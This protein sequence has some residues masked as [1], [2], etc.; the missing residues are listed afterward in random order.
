MNLDQWLENVVAN[1]PGAIYRCELRSD[2][3]M[4][5]MSREIEHITG[6]PPS[7]FVGNA[8]RTY[9]SVIHPDDRGDVESAV[10]AAVERHE[11]F[12]IDYRVL[13]ADGSPAGFVET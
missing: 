12:T 10:V 6:H 9:E 1:V 5:F 4:R 13:H 7:D 2:W 8:V 11:P 3:E